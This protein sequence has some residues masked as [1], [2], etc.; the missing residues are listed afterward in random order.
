MNKKPF[1]IAAPLA[2]YTNLGYRRFLKTFGVDLTVSE[3]ISDFAL[4]Y[5]NKETL[6]MVK[7]SL[8][9][10]PVALQLFGGSKESLLKG[11]EV[12]QEVATYDY[13][14]LNF[15]CPVNKVFKNNAGSAFLKN[16]RRDELL[17]TVQAIVNL[18]K[19][20]VSAKIRLGIN[21]DNINVVETCKI[22]EKAGV[23]LITIHGRTKAQ[24]YAG[25]ANYDYIKLAKEAV[26]VKIIAN[27]D[28]D[29]LSKAIEVLNYTKADGIALGRGILGNP[30]LIT[31]IKRYYE[32][33]T[34]LKDPT[35]KEQ[36]EYLKQHYS[37]LK[38]TKNVERAIIE[39]RGIA[40]HYLNRFTNIK[41]YK[42]KLSMI[43]NEDEL[44]SIIDEILLDESI[45]TII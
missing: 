16:E 14:D 31:Q 36:L 42:V 13:L 44:M 38:E 25:K 12:L 8:D 33:G 23:S 7:T 1:I 3:M 35:L 29:S 17:D 5:H 32:D 18:S 30:Y 45:K 34:I 15:G 40:P 4:I 41:K 27:G 21:E 43:K 6:N 20:P 37:L 22:L 11:L 28:I 39:M 9:E 2:G 10:R 26:K 24:L 19:V